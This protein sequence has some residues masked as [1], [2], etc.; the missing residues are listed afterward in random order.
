MLIPKY[1]QEISE[2]VVVSKNVEKIKIKCNCGHS[3][4]YVYVVEQ[5][6][7]KIKSGFSEI[8][9]QNNKLYLVKRNFFG[10]IVKKIECD[11]LFN[12]KQRKIVKVKC[13]KCNKEHILFDNYKHG[14]DAIINNIEDNY[15]NLDSSV[16]FKLSYSQPI[17]VY[18]QI[19]QDISYDEFQQEF[20]NLN[21]ETYLC[22]FSNID[23]YGLNTKLRKIKICSEETA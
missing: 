12:K 14:Y 18:L 4:F 23:I 8:I 16:K 20:E 21:F 2:S 13:A 11:D 10:R 3:H 17:K 5:D 1:L 9:R 7:P 15:L 6:T 19:Y 22:S